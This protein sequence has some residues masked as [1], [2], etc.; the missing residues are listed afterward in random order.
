VETLKEKR[1]NG[2]G[3][4]KGGGKRKWWRRKR[5]K[6]RR[7]RERRKGGGK[8]T[9]NFLETGLA[10]FSLSPVGNKFLLFN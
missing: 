10:S 4:G 9:S 8:K 5:K 7:R 1:K 2:E 3:E 6:R